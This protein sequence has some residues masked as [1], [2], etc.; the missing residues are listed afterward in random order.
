MNVSTGF[1]KFRDAYSFLGSAYPPV[2]EVSAQQ[3][4]IPWLSDGQLA[5]ALPVVAYWA[6]SMVFHTI[7]TWHLAEKFRIHPSEEVQT[8]NRVSR[9]EVLSEV[10]LQH[11]IQSVTGAAMLYFD[12]QPSTGFEKRAMW[13]WRHSLPAWVPSSVIFLWYSYGMS[14]LKV[15]VGFCI[16]DSWQYWLHRLMHTNKTLYRLYHSRHHRLYV[17]YAYGALYNSPTEGFLLDTLGTGIAAI[18]TG[19]THREQALLFTFATLKTVDDHCGYALPWD[20]FQWLFPNNAVYHDIHHQQFG[21]KTNFAQ[22]FFTLWD[23]VCGTKFHGFEQYEKAQRRI[24]IDKYKEFLQEREAEK[25]ARISKGFG[26]K[27]EN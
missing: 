1:D 20:P 24:T 11:V 27:K 14:L 2:V 15:F 16:I 22:P 9:K 17:P 6:F 7:D 19:L 13:D 3:P 5:L 25:Q 4:L 21:I 12:P 23:K 26:S 10:L 8:R 18:V